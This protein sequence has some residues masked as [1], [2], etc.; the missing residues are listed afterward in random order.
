M[1]DRG[2]FGHINLVV[3]DVDAAI[4]FYG[5]LGL[6]FGPSD[7]FPPGSGARHANVEPK[8]QVD[9]DNTRMARL[10]GTDALDAGATVVCFGLPSRDAVD[11]KYAALTAAGHRGT[12]EPY[13]AFWG[14]RF[15]I[16]EDPDGRPIGLMSPQDRSTSY[17]PEV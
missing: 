1:T 4:A 8:G 14:A 11:E 16:V 3:G 5:L 13:D 6:D 7:E 10:W 12:R 9:L 15:A 17:T 2:E